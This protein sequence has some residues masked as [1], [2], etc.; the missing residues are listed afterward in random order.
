MHPARAQSRITL[1]DISS[2][3]GCRYVVVLELPGRRRRPGGAVPDEMGEARAGPRQRAQRQEDCARP[4][5]RPTSNRRGSRSQSSP[6]PPCSPE[7]EE[8]RRPPS[9]GDAI[10]LSRLQR[11]APH[12]EAAPAVQQERERTRAEEQRR[13]R[14]HR[15]LFHSQLD[16]TWGSCRLGCR[17]PRSPP[18]PKTGLGDAAF[19]PEWVSAHSLPA[20]GGG[21]GALLHRHLQADR[22]AVLT[23]GVRARA[24]VVG[25]RTVTRVVD[26]AGG[27]GTAGGGRHRRPAARPERQGTSRARGGQEPPGRP[28]LPRGLCSPAQSGCVRCVGHFR[29]WRGL[30]LRDAFSDPCRGDDRGSDDGRENSPCTAN[31][32]DRI[33]FNMRPP[34]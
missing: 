19:T 24:R 30:S 25:T 1:A 12:A 23:A 2:A 22:D 29:G 26:A 6:G 10:P 13:R 15:R 17:R 7:D 8:R 11:A 9:P 18:V 21:R 16:N 14:H 4:E 27:P 5:A 34:S 28:E 31:F 3:P 20:L 32:K 33:H